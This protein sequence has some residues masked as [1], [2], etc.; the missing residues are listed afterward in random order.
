MEKQIEEILTVPIVLTEILRR[1][2]DEAGSYRQEC[3]ELKKQ[4]DKLA[5][6]L[7][8]VARVSSD[9]SGRLYKRPT[10]RIMQDLE[11]SVNKALMLVKKCKKNGCFKRV[12]TITSGN[13]FRRVNGLLD[14]GIADITWLLNV[15]ASVDERSNFLGLPPVASTDPMLAFIWERIAMLQQG[16]DDQR[17]DAV[18]D[19]FSVANIHYRNA[20]IILEE[21]GVPS[22]LK[23][24]CE[25]RPA[26]AE[27]AARALGL[28]ARDRDSVKQIAID[29]AIPVFVKILSD[30]PMKVQAA[31]A[32]VVAK[33]LS[34]D[35]DLQADFSQHGIVK[36]LVSLLVF[37]TL[38]ESAKCNMT[39]HS[40]VASSLAA[41]KPGVL[42]HGKHEEEQ[43]TGTIDG[44]SFGKPPS[45][46][47]L[48]SKPKSSSNAAIACKT[49]GKT[50]SADL[51]YKNTG[52]KHLESIREEKRR[53]LTPLEINRKQREKED[54]QVK[55]ELKTEAARALWKLAKGNPM[56]SKSITETKALLCFA[57]LMET[58]TCTLQKNSVMA[59]M[60][61]AAVAEKNDDLRRAA[62]KTSS[63]AAKAVVEQLLRLVEEG[64]P[65][66]QAPCIKAIG[67]LSRTFP[68]RE[69]R[70]VKPLVKQLEGREDVATEAVVA[71]VKFVCTENYLH[72]E[73]SKA[74]L[75]APGASHLVQLIYFGEG[76]VQVS[77]VILMCYLALHV[78]DSDVLAKAGALSI[79]EWVARTASLMQDP[80]VQKLLHLAVVKLEIYQGKGNFRH[81]PHPFDYQRF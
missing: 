78:G 65:D 2:L 1:T 33:M 35:T 54:P 12:F 31:V 14:N 58:C 47:V 43:N 13:N 51:Q 60:E 71:L 45:S 5:T 11:K 6:L 77:A 64:S 19:L 8:A 80:T 63:P 76:Q 37:E 59:V 74:V 52:N 23:L 56:T 66:L 50:G 62:F 69:T 32:W 40:L 36:P 41:N 44:M 28:L 38:D 49:S 39:V 68:A 25:G 46:E 20:K 3:A 24:L 27:T 16:N 72:I 34:L 17:E 73:H 55:T 61:I 21:E 4:A 57:K 48:G 18:N 10:R 7:R 70:V 67:C 42:T 30:S 22:M 26:A 79:L 29:G 75:E 81:N 9:A 53:G 15:S